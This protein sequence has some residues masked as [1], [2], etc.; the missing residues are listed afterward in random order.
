LTLFDTRDITEASKV[1]V[2]IKAGHKMAGVPIRR[3]EARAEV[4]VEEAMKV[5]WNSEEFIS[6]T[7]KLDLASFY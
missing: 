4:S 5:F 3:L 6:R 1:T 7:F 2:I